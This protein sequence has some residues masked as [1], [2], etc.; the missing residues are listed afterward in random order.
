MR[1]YGALI[2]A[3]VLA[4]SGGLLGAGATA[5]AVVRPWM[6]PAA[7]PVDRANAQMTLADT[8]A[9]MH[10]GASCGYDACVDP[11]TRLGTPQLRLH[12]ADRAGPDRRR[13][14]DQ[15]AGAREQT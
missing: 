2:V 12:P 13:S 11:N 5:H 7:T 8:I 6:N 10:Q 9:V 15:P 1:R 4:L 14:R 3:A